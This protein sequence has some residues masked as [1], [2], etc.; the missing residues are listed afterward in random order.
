MMARAVCVK[1]GMDDKNG[2]T[3]RKTKKNDPDRLTG[4]EDQPIEY[5]N[6]RF[7]LCERHSYTH[8]RFLF[9]SIFILRMDM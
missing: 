2:N 1:N 5:T 8:H 7:P 3:T 6:L 9:V 4:P